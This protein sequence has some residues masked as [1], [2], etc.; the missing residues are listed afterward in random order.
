MKILA[1]I[2]LF[3]ASILGSIYLRLIFTLPLVSLGLTML[4]WAFFNR[5]LKN[6]SIFL[7]TVNAGAVVLCAG[8]ALTLLNAMESLRPATH[9]IRRTYTADY[10]TPKTEGAWL[11]SPSE[12]LGYRYKQGLAP[13]R[14]RL[15][16]ENSGNV[17]YDV[18]YTFDSKGLRRTPDQYKTPPRKALF[19]GGSFTFGEGLEDSQTLPSKF[20]QSTG[21]Y[22]INAGMHGYGSHQALQSL[23]DQ[24][25]Y[26]RLT[27]GSHIDLIVYRVMND[28]ANRAAGMS[29]WDKY[30]PCFTVSNI[31]LIQ[32]EGSFVKCKNRVNLKNYFQ[33]LLSFLTKTKE[34][35]SRS[36][37]QRMNEAFFRD[38]AERR[39]VA[40]IV[41]MQKLAE[42]RKSH[43]VVVNET[44][45]APTTKSSSSM[46][47]ECQIDPRMLLLTSHLTKRGIDVINTHE[48]YS[49]SDCSTDI[50]AIPDDG[51]PSEYANSK[52]A[53]ELLTTLRKTG[54][55]L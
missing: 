54:L 30:G 47:N 27:A 21:W 25:T 51:H 26:R 33:K 53:A 4:L 12:P 2:A 38:H 41:E 17:I 48:I 3:I 7:I 39:Q 20:A 44:V 22:S 52:V 8:S 55:D 1:L 6:K 35:F 11:S 46:N 13:M 29:E 19:L 36:V 43:F 50:L 18:T 16:E 15:I 31:G 49:K 9:P 24:G 37:V 5:N 42:L 34:P 23:R 32:Y 45:M 40:I 14:S 28:H 10:G